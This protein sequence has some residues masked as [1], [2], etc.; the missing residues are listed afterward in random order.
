MDI[1][2]VYWHQRSNLRLDRTLRSQLRQMGGVIHALRLCETRLR[3]LDSQVGERT[4]ITM[5]Y[6]IY[7]I[8][9]YNLVGSLEHDFYFPMYWE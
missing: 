2:V 5:V 9:N 4:T 1:H 8:Y 7:N 3:T 6:D